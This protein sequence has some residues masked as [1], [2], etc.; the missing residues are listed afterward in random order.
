MTDPLAWFDSEVQKLAERLG[1]A[2][3]RPTATAIVA[4]RRALPWACQRVNRDPTAVLPFDAGGIDVEV[5]LRLPAHREQFRL[6][7]DEPLAANDKQR[8]LARA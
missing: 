2:Y 3:D 6:P 7:Q 1:D 4:A 8:K 5:T